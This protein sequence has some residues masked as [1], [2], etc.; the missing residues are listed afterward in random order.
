M[1]SEEKRLMCSCKWIFLC[2]FQRTSTYWFSW[3][4]LY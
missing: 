4:F 2:S 1:L 3:I